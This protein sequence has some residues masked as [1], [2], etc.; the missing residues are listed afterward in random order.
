MAG[1]ISGAMAN[2]ASALDRSARE[3]GS[4]LFVQRVATNAVRFSE[5]DSG[6]T[7]PAP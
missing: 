2:L 1:L 7:I 6:S 3:V 5:I 4:V